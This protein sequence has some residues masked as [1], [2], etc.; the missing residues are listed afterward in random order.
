MASTTSCTIAITL[1]GV[2]FSWSS[3]RVLVPLIVG[4][5]GFLLSI[6]Y[7]CCFAANSLVLN[8]ILSENRALIILVTDN[9]V[10]HLKQDNTKRVQLS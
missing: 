9:L 3:A 8:L 5:I 4:F 10:Y 6:V 2:A 7:E 1:G